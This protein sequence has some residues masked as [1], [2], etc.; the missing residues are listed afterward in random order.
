MSKMVIQPEKCVHYW[1]IESPHGPTSKG[2]CRYCGAVAE[3]F[4]DLQG[5]LNNTKIYAAGIYGE[6]AILQDTDSVMIDNS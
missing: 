3:F 6:R 2:Q 4:N 1:I 5:C